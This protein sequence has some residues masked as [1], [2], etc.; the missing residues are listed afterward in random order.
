MFL[1][2]FLTIGRFGK[3]CQLDT[4]YNG[5]K[6]VLKIY[7]AKDKKFWDQERQVF[8]QPHM[9]DHDNIVRFLGAVTVGDD[10]AVVLEFYSTTLASHLKGTNS[11]YSD[12]LLLVNI[13]CK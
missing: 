11:L 8:S 5:Y 1:L 6:A 12:T 7:M 13:S 2:M 3:V 10:F 4:P 9:S